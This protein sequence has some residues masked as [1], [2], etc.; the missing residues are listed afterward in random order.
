MTMPD[1]DALYGPSTP[2]SDHKAGGM[3]HFRED[4]ELKQGKILHVRA[5]GPAVQGGVGHGVLYVVDAGHGFPSIVAPGDV[6]EGSDIALPFRAILAS[7]GFS[8]STLKSR[9]EALNLAW[10]LTIQRILVDTGKERLR[11]LDARVEGDEDQGK[12]VAECEAVEEEA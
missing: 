1:S 6:V 7:Y 3:V 9:E 2:F 4:G 5:P 10:N 8:G 11:I 12:V